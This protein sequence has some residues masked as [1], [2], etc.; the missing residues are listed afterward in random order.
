MRIGRR[1]STTTFEGHPFGGLVD[2]VRLSSIDRAPED[3]HGCH[4]PPGM[5]EEANR[6]CVDAVEASVWDT[7][8]CDG[9]QFGVDADDYP[10]P[11]SGLTGSMF[12]CAIPGAQPSRF[13]SWAQARR[14]CQLGGGGRRL[15]SS[16]EW[17]LACRGV[18][19]T[20]YPYAGDYDDAACADDGA[21]A[22]TGSLAGCVSPGGAWD[23]SGN[24]AEWVDD[25]DV[26]PF[27][28]L[29]GAFDAGAASDLACPPAVGSTAPSSAIVETLATTS[30][31]DVGL[32][33]CADPLPGLGD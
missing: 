32:R 15:C 24:V 6:T 8:A 30:R 28:A 27:R 12:A 5:V 16:D 18:D 11:D 2:E 13:I 20:D 23:L 25:G 33:C 22:P 17:T 7:K 1:Y 3:L 4:C 9:T 26:G 19:D 21:V 14:A 29:G 31:D 10:I